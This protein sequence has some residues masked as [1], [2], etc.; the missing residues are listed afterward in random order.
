MS[1]HICEI[2][3]KEFKF[4]CLLIRHT[5]GKRKCTPK[6]NIQSI[7][8]S[9]VHD[10]PIDIKTETEPIQ[11]KDDKLLNLYEQFFGILSVVVKNKKSNININELLKLKDN[12]F[13]DNIDPIILNSEDKKYS[14]IKCNTVFC[15]RQNLYRHNKLNRCKGTQLIKNTEMISSDNVNII[16]TSSIDQDSLI[17][18]SSNKKITFN[19][20]INPEINNTVNNTIN[21]T[22][23]TNNNINFNIPN[24]FGCESLDHI[25]LNDFK[26]IF[27]NFNG[28]LQKI[29]SYVYTKNDSNKS[30]CKINQNKSVVTYLDKNLDVINVSESEFIEELKRN[31][32]NLAI[33]MF[34]IF[35]SKLT[36]DELVLY[37]RNLLLCQEPYKGINN[38]SSN[39]KLNKSLNAIVDSIFRD[40]E[41]KQVLLNIESI[42][43]K[44]SDIIIPF[45]EKS[46][47]THKQK[48]SIIKEYST[49]PLQISSNNN[50]LVIIDKKNLFTIKE[51][52]FLEN[53][54]A[55][56]NNL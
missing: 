56:F 3:N 14:C 54:K 16:N 2:C 45:K 30:F 15:N 32:N 24:A 23:Q 40:D 31:I 6:S 36:I 29:C 10:K 46:L 28:I 12:I 9:I 50:E 7:N 22:I 34:H 13:K 52:A 42:T 43:K 17:N 39:I 19:E 35:K 44:D 1:K 55:K 51:K 25:T 4:N 11:K 47:D 53:E 20:L 5:Q 33:E 18:N 38:K 48:F 8:L 41:I 27:H 26:I 21:L 37:M 49:D